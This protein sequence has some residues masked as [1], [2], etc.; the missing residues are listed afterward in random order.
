M[1]NS[2]G[3]LILNL[4]ALLIM[5]ATSIIFFHKQRQKKVEVD[6]YARLLIITNLGTL[7]GIILGLFVNP[8]M[9]FPI[10]FIEILNKIYLVFLMLWII[11]LTFYTLAIS[12]VPEKKIPTLKKIFYALSFISV[13]LTFLLPIEVTMTEQNTLASGL[14]IIFSYAVFAIGFVTQ[15]FCVILDYKNAKNKKY[16]PIYLLAFF[17]IFVLI[18]QMLNPS[19]NYL[20]NPALVFITF[21]MYH[22]IENPDLRLIQELDF[23]KERAEKANHAKTEFL[24][25]MSHEIRTPLNAIVGFSTELKEDDS[26]RESARNE[27][28]DIITASNNL[29]EIVN[30]ILDIS[31]IEANKLE[32]VEVEYNFV[33]IFKELVSLTEVRIGEKN[34]KFEA[35]YDPMLPGILYGDATRLK[36]IILNLLTNAAK[37]TKEGYIWFKVSTIVKDDV[38]RLIISVEDTGIGIKQENIPKLFTKFERFDMKK[39]ST[40]EGTGLGLAITKRLVELMHGKIV[41]QSVYGKGSKF[42]VAIDQK[43]VK[44]ERDIEEEKEEETIEIPDFSSKKILVVDDNEMNL[45]VANLFL[46][47]YKVQID[48]AMN[49][50]ECIEKVQ[51]NS[52]DLILLDDMMPK[53]SGGETLQKLKQIPGFHI[54]TIALTANALSGMKE[55]YIKDGFSDYLAKPIEK[56]ELNRVLCDF[57]KK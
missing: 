5:I 16:V 45:K 13:L 4:Y 23:A 2:Q 51:N 24:S 37:Y 52:Y 17:G 9:N 1:Q 35:S 38:C 7:S 47:K 36:Q 21:I 48:T 27:I 31:K 33:K 43:I 22:T 32:I 42:T 10:I 26:I 28:E 6:T 15:I 30:G 41:V 14:S 49:G 50:F 44:M 46:K 54:P 25:N 3:F 39:N 8:H 55:K 34:I 18:L 11:V 40:I 53:M 19:L 20:V 56:R 57:L 29:L 12:L